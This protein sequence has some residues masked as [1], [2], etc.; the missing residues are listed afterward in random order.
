MF[1]L[2][3]YK[4]SVLLNLRPQVHLF[5]VL[6]DEVGSTHKVLLQQTEEEPLCDKH[7]NRDLNSSFSQ[8]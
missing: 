7:L 4:W 1:L 3:Q 6:R 2:K 5:S 8:F